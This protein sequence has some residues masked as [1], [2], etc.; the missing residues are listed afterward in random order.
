MHA[1]ANHQPMVRLVKRTGISRGRAVVYRILAVA[2]ALVTGGIFLWALGQNPLTVY[3]TM[4]QGAAG[5][6]IALRETIKIAIPLCI[7]ALGITLAFKMHFWNI[8]AE[9]Q[10]CLGAIAA[11]YFALFHSDWP[12]PVLLIT[13]AVAGILAGGLWGAIPAVFKARFGTNETLLTLMLNYVASFII[14]FL[15]EGPW[16]DPNALGFPKIAMFEKSAR[17]PAV[18]GVHAGWIIALVLVVLV[19]VY[20]KYTKQGY[21]LSVVGE[22]ENTARYAGM[23]VR[24]IIVRTMFLSAAICGLA[25]MLQ[26]SGADK[27]LTDTVAGGVGF[28]AITVAWLSQLNPFAILLVSFLFG[29]LEKGSGTIQSLLNIS[30][31]AAEVL[32]GIVLFF[33]L[34]SEFFINFRVIWNRGGAVNE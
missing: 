16:K 32:Q 18:L 9:G 31:S 12:Q 34:G 28:T 19:F 15:R 23:N 11:S 30:P 1:K 3:A 22:N 33:V 29:C 4:I 8:G 21:E 24:K 14:Q 27:T 13:M 26:A 10:I 5:T 7:T 20:M 2:L 17:M 6:K 25:G